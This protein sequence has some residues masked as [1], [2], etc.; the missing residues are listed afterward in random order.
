MAVA[1]RKAAAPEMVE[2]VAV[3]TIYTAPD[4]AP[5]TPGSSLVLEPAEAAR[6]IRLGLA[7]KP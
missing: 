1:P 5:A 2:V 4:K 6:L 7:R 3:A